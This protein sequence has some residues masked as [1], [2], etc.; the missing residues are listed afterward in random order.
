MP[1]CTRG[2]RWR[3]RRRRI[4]REEECCGVCEVVVAACR[5]AREQKRQSLSTK[6]RE[7][8]SIV[9]R[10]GGST[11]YEDDYLPT[12]TSLS[13]LPQ[14]QWEKKKN[15]DDERNMMMMMDCEAVLAVLPK[16]ERWKCDGVVVQ[17]DFACGADVRCSA[18][19]TY[20]SSLHLA[21][22]PRVDCRTYSQ[23]TNSGD[24]PNTTRPRGEL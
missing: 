8:K 1:K 20:K 12:T 10:T 7:G 16:R 6:E 5:C 9:W 18:R 13:D 22:S 3:R 21:K 2:R 23:S 11:Y 15:D 19:Q 24:T 14:W 4:M 17:L